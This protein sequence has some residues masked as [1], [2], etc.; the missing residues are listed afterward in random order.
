MKKI[1][2]HFWIVFFFVC[3]LGQ[4]KECQAQVASEIGGLKTVSLGRPV[5]FLVN[6]E[7]RSTML[8]NNQEEI[9]ILNYKGVEQGTGATVFYRTAEDGFMNELNVHLDQETPN[10]KY[11]SEQFIK[12]Q[13]T[14]YL[15]Y[16]SHTQSLFEVLSDGSKNVGVT[17]NVIKVTVNNIN[18]SLEMV[19]NNL[20]FLDKNNHITNQKFQIN[21]TVGGVVY[22]FFA[23]LKPIDLMQ[24]PQLPNVD[25]LDAN[26]QLNGLVPGVIE[27]DLRNNANVVVGK[28][29]IQTGNI[30]IFRL[31]GSGQLSE[32]VTLPM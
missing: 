25:V 26:N 28:L 15:S 24:L 30:Q 27:A 29:K 7:G 10:K 6:E 17:V 8:N 19:I 12:I 13:K 1:I 31:S 2:C 18:A 22:P 16:E 20:N 32:W 23:G 9:A 3:L 14:D 21:V 11:F 5:T 4:K